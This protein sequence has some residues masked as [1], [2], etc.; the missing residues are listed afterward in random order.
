MNEEIREREVRLIGAD[1]SQVGIVSIADALRR[2]QEAGLDLVEVAADAKPPVCKIYDYKKVL[3]EKKK[4]V[5]ESKKKTTQIQLKE[6][7]VRVAIDPHDLS[8]KLKHA[9]EFLEKGDKVKFTI[10]FRGREITHPELGDK[11]VRAV[12]DGLADIGEFD[13]P[14]IRMG[15]SLNI[16]MS[17]R[18]DWAPKPAPKAPAA[19]KP[20]ASPAPAPAATGDTPKT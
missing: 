15:K 1:G 3:Y 9:R 8:I 6:L 19:P 11:V 12:R 14:P 5:R 17:R 2:A 20:Q 10:L 16:V 4:K 13:A 18:K 7:K